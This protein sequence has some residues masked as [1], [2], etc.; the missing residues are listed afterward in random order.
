MTLPCLFLSRLDLCSFP[1]SLTTRSVGFMLVSHTDGLQ[2]GRMDR[3]ALCS[4]NAPTVS[5]GDGWI[6]QPCA[7]STHRWHPKGT[8]RQSG[9]VLVEQLSHPSAPAGLVLVSHASVLQREQ[10]CRPGLCSFHTRVVI[11]TAASCS[12][13]VDE[14]YSQAV[15]ETYPNTSFTS[16]QTMPSS[17][18]STAR[19]CAAARKG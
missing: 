13:A 5:K 18:S 2:R 11:H 6:E 4:L 16:L 1:S 3:A 8:D 14:T 19:L 7:R 9:L 12:G 15:D 10:L 17:T